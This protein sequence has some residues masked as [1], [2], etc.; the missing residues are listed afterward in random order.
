MAARKTHNFLPTV[1][2][3]DTNK[4][5]LSA[6]VDQLV[7]EP[8]F[9]NLYGYIG[10]KF[11]PTFKSGD[12]YIAE[13]NISRQNYQL[14]PSVVI[15]DSKKNITFFATYLDLLDKIKHYGG[16]VN[17]HSRLFEQEYY[18]FD[19]RISYDKLVN[20]SQYYWL[21]NGPNPVAV[22]TSGIDLNI[23]Y[24]VTRDA[25]N[26]RYVFTNNGVVDNSIILA[27]GGTYNFVVNQ[28]GVPFWIQ[29]ED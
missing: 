8:D 2:Q 17:N 9:V 22:N 18:S 12:S 20:F 25:A 29:S 6:T 11:A 5:F 15:K 23:T 24:V 7:S 4:K 27:R 3:T 28:P 26:G 16:D 13:P 1:F 19:P 21:P 14:E 10:R